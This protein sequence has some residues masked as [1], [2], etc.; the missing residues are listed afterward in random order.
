MKFRFCGELDC[1]DWI[2]AEIATLSKITSI[3]M[4]LLCTQVADGILGA[5]IDFDK[6]IKLTSDAKYEKGDIKAT[7]AALSF[8]FISSAKH[9]IEEE[10][11]LKKELQQL[12]LPKESTAAL[13]KVYSDKYAKLQDKLKKDSLKLTEI[14]SL[15]WQVNYIISSS[16]M[17][18]V[19][20]PSVQLNL[21]VK[22]LGD[23]DE[24]KLQTI[25]MSSKKFLLLL[26]ELK[27][28]YSI[29][30]EVTSSS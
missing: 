28:A 13:C 12:G 27:Q 23:E 26:H 1:P 19:S 17:Q 15:D 5:P 7:V 16:M 8:I 30:E 4:K 6:I 3:K 21:K 18:D 9:G 10:S 11:L 22:E 29:M 24:P 25:S 2:L 20:D 14:S